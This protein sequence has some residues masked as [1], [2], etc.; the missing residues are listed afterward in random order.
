M[1]YPDNTARCVFDFTLPNGSHGYVTPHVRSLD[2]SDLG[3]ADVEAIATLLADWAVNDNFEGE[4]NAALMNFG[5]D[6]LTLSSITV[7]S[8]KADAPPQFAL[9]VNDPGNGAGT[10][11]PNESALVVTLYTGLVGRRY[12]GRNFW[13]VLTV[14]MMENNGTLAGVTVAAFQTTF[15][16][17]IAGLEAEGT[18]VLAV[19]SDVGGFVNQ[20]ISSIVRDT[21]HHQ[22]RR[23]N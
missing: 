21:V 15:D 20:A 23:N 22:R 8:L 9:A 18:Y 3:N 1:A 14:A 6:E 17:L 16:A 2:G 7:T 13:P 5:P 4:T 10:P 12:R 19:N 11:M